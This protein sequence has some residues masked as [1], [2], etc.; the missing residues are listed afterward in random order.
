MMAWGADLAAAI[1]LLGGGADGAPTTIVLDDG[2]GGSGSGSGLA[3]FAD[4]QQQPADPDGGLQNASS[5]LRLAQITL[6]LRRGEMATAQRLWDANRSIEEWNHRRA[7]VNETVAMNEVAF[8][9]SR[10]AFYS[11]TISAIGAPDAVTRASL[12]AAAYAAQRAGLQARLQSAQAVLA[13]ELF[14]LDRMNAANRRSPHAFL[15]AAFIQANADIARAREAVRV[16][17]DAVRR[18]P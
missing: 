8:W 2:G 12:I 3:Q 14:R 16:A 10:V 9:Q 17:E 6:R 11:L 7:Q 15:E 1:A 18:A 13:D 5:K 4:L